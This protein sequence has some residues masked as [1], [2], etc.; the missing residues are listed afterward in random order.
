MARRLALLSA[1]LGARQ[2][3]GSPALGAA[4]KSVAVAGLRAASVLGSS[5]TQLWQQCSPTRG[6]ASEGESAAGYEEWDQISYPPARAFVGQVAPDFEA[7]AVIDGE[8]RKISLSDYRG[9]Y[10]VLFWYPKDF[11][12]VCPTGECSSSLSDCQQLGCSKLLQEAQQSRMHVLQKAAEIIAFSDRFKEFDAIDCQVI[13]A[14]TDTEECHLAWIKTPRNRGG[15]GYTQI[16]IVADTTKAIAARYGVLLEKAGIALRGLFIINPDGII[17]QITINDLPIGRSVDETLRLVQAIQF[18][19]KYG[20]VCPANWKP[21]DKTIIADP[22]R[23]LDYFEKAHKEAA[24]EEE[25]GAKLTPINNRR[26][27][28]ALI[29]GNRPVVDDAPFVDELAEKHPNMVFAKFDT[30]ME[31][32]EPLSAELNVKALPVFRFYKPC[33]VASWQG[34]KKVAEQAGGEEVVEQ[35]G[36]KVMI[37]SPILKLCNWHHHAVFGKVALKAVPEC[38][39]KLGSGIVAV[40]NVLVGTSKAQLDEAAKTVFWRSNRDAGLKLGQAKCNFRTMQK[41]VEVQGVVVPMPQDR[42]AK[43]VEQILRFQAQVMCCMSVR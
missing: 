41:G 35:P 28:E 3:F 22:E 16:P 36:D 24:A 38:I 26:D 37:L 15:L 31:Q 17:Q 21:G 11:T 32:L 10:V 20:E 7:P 4:E 23:S 29:Q 2:L 8:I 40:G 25:F 34:D 12:F 18:H 33:P 13:A 5:T 27:F 1:R 43:I 14:S 9:K 6:F 42:V 30:S 19:A 39:G